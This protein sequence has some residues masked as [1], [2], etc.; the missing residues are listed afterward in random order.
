MSIYLY[1]KLE[2]D[3]VSGDGTIILEAN[4]S[5]WHNQLIVS[6]GTATA[7]TLTIKYK[8]GGKT[9]ALKDQYG[10]AI[11]MALTADPEPIRFDGLIDA[12]VIEQSGNNGT[13]NAL[14]LGSQ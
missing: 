14:L 13:F 5:C 2:E 4:Q 7:G 12:V 8:V 3:I 6:R 10:V 9:F 11:T 1:E